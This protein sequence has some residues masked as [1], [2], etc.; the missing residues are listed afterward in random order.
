RMAID[1]PVDRALLRI[2]PDGEQRFLEMA[3]ASPQ[4]IDRSVCQW[5]TARLRLEMPI[6]GYRFL[7]M[8]GGEALWFTAAGL[9]RHWVTDADDFRLLAGYRSPAWTHAT[10][11]YQ[12][13]PDRFADG[14]SSNNV[15]TGEFIYRGRESKARRW[16]EPPSQGWDAMVEFYGG[17][18]AGIGDK[19]P[20]LADLGVNA[21]YLNPI[22][23]AYSNHR[24]DVTDYDHVDPHLGGNAALVELRRKTAELDFRLILDIVPNHCGILHPWFQMAQQDENAPTADFFSF[25]HHPDQ[26]EAWMG[27]PT[28]PRLDYHS[29]RLRAVMYAGPESIFRHWLRSP[30]ALDGWRIDVA[31][32]LG[33]QGADQLDV[34][35]GQGIRRAVKEENPEAYLLGEN[36]F[37]ASRHLQGDMWDAAMNYAGFSKPLW[38]WLSGFAV[39]QHG[40]PSAAGPQR[41]PTAALVESWQAYRAAIPWQIAVQQFNLLGSHDTERILSRLNG[42]PDLNRLAVGLQMTYPG[43]PC[44]YYGDEVGLTNQNNSNRVTMPWDAGDWDQGLRS[45]YQKLIELRRTSPALIAG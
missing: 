20:Y 27:V 5:M 28:L 29:A 14:D 43:V 2:C 40:G 3:P 4:D 44:V 24:Y 32:M 37:D 9:Q 36:F 23:T 33:R 6:T 8:V 39:S 26:Y 45:F 21:L 10:V 11:F 17:D 25:S 38:F 7:I 42:N 31:N 35:V 16:G 19:L 30:Y 12:I 18:L 13:F 41:W 34:E 22:F 1:A 15:K